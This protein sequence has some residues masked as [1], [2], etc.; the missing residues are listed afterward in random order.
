[1]TSGHEFS[2]YLVCFLQN[3]APLNLAVAE[4]AGAGSEPILICLDERLD[5]LFAK[6]PPDIQKPNRKAEVIS[7]LLDAFSLVVIT[8]GNQVQSIHLVALLLQKMG[9]NRTVHPA[10]KRKY[11]FFHNGEFYPMTL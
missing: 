11:Y 1:M 7:D 3:Q 2:S 8:P 5:H 4:N 10:A 9:G 6:R